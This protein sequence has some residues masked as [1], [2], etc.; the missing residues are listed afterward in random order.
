MNLS[1]CSCRNG[2]EMLWLRFE[3]LKP[4]FLCY[5]AVGSKAV[6]SAHFPSD[7]FA[8]RAYCVEPSNFRCV[9]VRPCVRAC[10]RPS[11]RPLFFESLLD[12]F[13]IRFLVQIPLT[14]AF[15]R[16]KKWSKTVRTDGRT[17]ARTHGRTHTH[18]FV[19]GPHTISP[20][21]NKTVVAGEL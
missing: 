4:V 15:S 17:H 8:R 12:Q 13:R 19:Y 14:H 11:V 20:S 1:I 21:G 7:I 9:F 5:S 2:L 18:G 6:T 10:V 3:E 16:S